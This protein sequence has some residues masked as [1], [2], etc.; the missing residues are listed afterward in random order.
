MGREART[1]AG[2]VPVFT[3]LPAAAAGTEQ[4]LEPH[5]LG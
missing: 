5:R 2:H 4:V 1:F 3:A